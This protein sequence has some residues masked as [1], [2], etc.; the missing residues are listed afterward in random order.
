VAYVSALEGAVRIGTDA[1][2]DW[3]PASLNWPVT[4]GTQLQLDPVPA[5]SWTAAGWHCACRARVPWA[6]APST[7]PAPSGR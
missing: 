1:P 6:P 7:T 4:T 5:P 3:A 2:T